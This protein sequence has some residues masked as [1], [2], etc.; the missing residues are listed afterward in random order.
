MV[1]HSDIAPL[2]K[3]DPG[4]KFPWKK[5][6]QL[7][8]GIWHNLNT[9]VLLNNRN[10][11]VEKKNK[12]VFFKYLKK[13]GFQINFNLKKIKY[14]KKLIKAF[15]RRFRPEKISGILDEEC[16]LIAKNLSNY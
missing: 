5:L 11:T 10:K 7:G 15:Q 12:L 9:K 14:E 1:G 13:I 16:L 2:R 8:I 4:E 6:A 3:K